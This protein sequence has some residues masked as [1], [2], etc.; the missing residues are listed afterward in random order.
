ME[1]E[2]AVRGA[3]GH[4]GACFECTPTQQRVSVVFTGSGGHPEAGEMVV[5]RHLCVLCDARGRDGQ[6]EFSGLIAARAM[7]AVA[8]GWLGSPTLV[9]RKCCCRESHV[10]WAETPRGSPAVT[11]RGG[12]RRH[13]ALTDRGVPQGWSSS[14]YAQQTQ[15][16]RIVCS[17]SPRG[18]PT[19]ATASEGMSWHAEPPPRAPQAA[20]QQTDGTGR[21]RVL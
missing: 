16:S 21:W 20:L 19:Q 1:K 7:R 8:A 6:A 14:V 12:A 10:G 2:R 11:S 4:R 17:K 9:T 3:S 5:E 13:R 18:D 15:I